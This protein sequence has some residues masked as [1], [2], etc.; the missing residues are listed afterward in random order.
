MDVTATTGT[1]RFGL[2]RLDA[3]GTGL[4]RLD[5]DGTWIPVAI[6]SR[7]LD[8]LLLLRAP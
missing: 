7:A 5:D 8:L 3:R 6:G 2:F 4:S 1:Y